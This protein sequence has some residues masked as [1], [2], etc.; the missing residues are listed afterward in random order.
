MFTDR[1]KLLLCC[2][3]Y[4]KATDFKFIKEDEMKDFANETNVMITMFRYVMIN[5]IQNALCSCFKINF[6]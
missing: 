5:I 6:I 2:Y 3:K 1:A 4:A